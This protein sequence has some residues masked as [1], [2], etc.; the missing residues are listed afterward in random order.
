[1]A[2]ASPAPGS[3]VDG[4]ATDRAH[5][6]VGLPEPG[7]A[8]AVA[9][10]LAPH[11]GS[12]GGRRVRRRTHRT[13]TGTAGRSPRPR[14]G[15]PAPSRRRSA[16]CGR[17]RRRTA[18]SPRRR[19]RPCRARRRR[20]R[21]R[22]VRCR[23]EASGRVRVNSVPSSASRSAAVTTC[24]ERHSWP[25]SSGIAS[26]NRSCTS[27]SRASRSSVRASSSVSGIATALTLV[28]PGQRA[29]AA[30]SPA[31]T[32][33]SRSRRVSPINRACERVSS[34]IVTGRARRRPA[35]R[36]VRPARPR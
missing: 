9:L 7:G 31:S 22:P 12:P 3:P 27:R 15:R 35:R 28:R 33:S 6:P 20:P 29:A 1:M 16:G 10:L 26:M 2:A 19:C 14:T 23:A 8:D 24:S 11:R 4:S 30:C 17:S 34:E 32:A 25:P 5:R 21:G 36:P 18:W 13:A